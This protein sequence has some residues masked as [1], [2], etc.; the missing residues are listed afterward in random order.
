MC[1]AAGAAAT[2]AGKLGSALVC[3]DGAA[4][5]LLSVTVSHFAAL[6]VASLEDAAAANLFCL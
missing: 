3:P 1:C 5:T 2:P 6:S 4:P